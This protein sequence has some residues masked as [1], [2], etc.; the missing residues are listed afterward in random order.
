MA[1]IGEQQEMIEAPVSGS[2]YVAALD[3]KITLH[4]GA[5]SGCS[6]TELVSHCSGAFPDLVRARL[7]VLHL[8]A[9][10]AFKGSWATTRSYVSPELHPL[11][12][13]WHFSSQCAAEVAARLLQFGSRHLCLGAPTVASAL[14]QD[15]EVVLVDRNP[16]VRLRLPAQD[17]VQL[18][19]ADIEIWSTDASFDVAFLDPPWYE[20][21][22]IRWLSLACRVVERGGMIVCS[23]FPPLTR[24]MASQERQT[25]LEWA[26]RIG[27][28]DVVL[29]VLEYDTPLFEIEALKHAGMPP[30]GN[31]RRGD[32]LFLR[33]RNVLPALVGSEFQRRTEEWDTYIIG[34]QVLKLRRQVQGRSDEL[35]EPLCAYPDFVMTTVSGRDPQRPYVD[36]WSSRNRVARVGDRTT[37]AAVLTKLAAGAALDSAVNSL[38]HPRQRSAFVRVLNAFLA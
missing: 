34:S 15:A 6:F 31:W 4:L 13:E 7:E 3:R 37:V 24:P 28:P 5:H 2:E 23:L 29:D 30:I 25:I 8:S 1:T 20:Y 17:N 27:D 22:I 36:L 21:D 38:I 16:L 32:L 35:I 10:V 12:F 33:A 9:Q 11:D 14:P 19:I 18:E 26:S